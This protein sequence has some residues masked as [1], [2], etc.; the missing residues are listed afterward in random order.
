MRL[1][2]R[3]NGHPQGARHLMMKDDGDM[4]WVRVRVRSFAQYDA[5]YARFDNAYRKSTKISL[6]QN[7]HVQTYA[8]A[9]HP[10]KQTHMHFTYQFAYVKVHT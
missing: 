4:S 2:T 8:L 9:M 6:S 5:S 10:C 1:L 7:T 3:A